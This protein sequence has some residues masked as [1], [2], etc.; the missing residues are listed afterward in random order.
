MLTAARADKAEGRDVVVGLV[1]THGRRETE[2][3]VEGLEVLPRKPTIYVNQILSE[4]DLDKALG[5]PAE[6]AAGRRV[7]AHQHSR[8]PPSQAMAGRRGA[9]GGR[10]RRVDHAQH[11]AP[12]KPQRHPAEDHPRAS[13]RDGARPR[14]RGRRRDRTGRSAARRAAE[15][16]RGGQGLCARHGG[17]R[18][19]ALLQAAKPDRAAR[20]GPAARRRAHRRRPHRA[21]AGAGD[22]GPVGRRASASLPASAPM[23]T[24]R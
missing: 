23:P 12:R 6:T 13:A 4:F 9:A 14:V 7:C 8:Q 10:H 5:A 16:A 20:A 19:Q 1:E 15:A 17:P 11:P 22:R 18:A 2:A 24:R 21:H 3:L